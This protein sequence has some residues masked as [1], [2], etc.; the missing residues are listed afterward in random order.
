MLTLHCIKMTH[1]PGKEKTGNCLS[2]FISFSQILC[3]IWITYFS[4][5]LSK[6]HEWFLFPFKC[7][8]FCRRFGHTNATTKLLYTK[9]KPFLVV[10][11]INFKDAIMLLATCYTYHKMTRKEMQ[12]FS[13][14]WVFLFCVW[15]V[16]V[17]VHFFHP[18][19]MQCLMCSATE[20]LKHGI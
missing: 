12:M 20:F 3:N 18:P 16:L 17:N 13:I 1:A 2:L 4:K 19:K 7:T 9:S 5:V 14:L 6:Y 11:T 15:C 10:S 8:Y